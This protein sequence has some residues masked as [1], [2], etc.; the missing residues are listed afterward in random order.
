MFSFL[1]GPAKGANLNLAR[2]PLFLRVVIDSRDNKVDALDQLTDEPNLC[3]Q[4]HVYRLAEPVSRG[5][6]CSRGRGCSTFIVAKY[7]LHDEQPSDAVARDRE[8]WPVWAKQQAAAAQV[9][10]AGEQF[11][12]GM[13]ES[14]SG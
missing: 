3:E 4:V 14:V 8:A 12:S 5:F 13:A 2:A 7:L 11:V 6:A 9:T 1:D 10:A